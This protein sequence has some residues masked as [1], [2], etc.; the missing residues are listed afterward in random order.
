MTYK[1]GLKILGLG[2]T[3]MCRMYLSSLHSCC[4]DP[5]RIKGNFDH[6]SS[7]CDRTRVS[8]TGGSD[9]VT[10]APSNSALP[11]TSCPQ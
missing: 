3:V 2:V 5:W 4:T 6:Q 1:P 8:G 9:T 11:G 7:V 10:V